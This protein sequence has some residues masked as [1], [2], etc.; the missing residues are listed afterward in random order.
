MNLIQRLMGLML[1]VMFVATLAAC[2]GGGGGGSSGGGGGGAPLTITTGS[3]PNGTVGVAYSVTLQVTGGTSPYTWSV[4]QGSLP[5]WATLNAS[6]G[7]ITG[8]PNAAGTITLTFRATDSNNVTT[9]TNSLTLAIAPAA[10][11]P[12]TITTSSLPSGTVGVAYSASLQASGGTPPYTWSVSQG[13]LPSWATLN[14]NTGAI[15]GTPNAAGTTALTFSVTDSN[16]VI[17]Q[18]SSLNLTIAPAAPPPLAITTPSLPS[19][20]VGATYSTTLQASGGTPPYT[21]SISSGLLPAWASL[22]TSTGAITGTPNVSGTTSF[23][24]QVTDSESPVVSKTQNL[25]ITVNASNTSDGLLSGQYAFMVSGYDSALAGSISVDG[26]G[27]ITGGEED[28]AAPKTS[29]SG[30]NIPIT[31]GTYTVGSDNRGTLSYTDSNGN[32]FTFAFA[33]GGVSNGVAAQGQMIEFDT[34]P[35]EMSGQL[36]LQ[37]AAAFSPSALSGPYVLALPG[38]DATP[39]PDVVIGSF[40]AGPGAISSGLLDQNDMGTVT[41]AQAFTGNLGS[42]DSKGRGTMTLTVGAN[43][44]TATLY[45]VSAGEWFLVGGTSGTPSFVFGGEVVQQSA[46]P[47]SAASLSGPTIFESRSE[48]GVPAPNV[49]FGEITFGSG[50]INAEIDQDDGGTLTLGQSFSGGSW[51]VTSASNGRFLFSPG[52]AHTQ[53]GYW[54]APDLAVMT[55]ESAVT[56]DIGTLEPQSGS[57]FSNSS[58]SGA[59]FLGTLPSLSPGAP[60]QNGGAAPPFNIYSGIFSASSGACSMTLDINSSGATSSGVTGS[61][62]CSVATNGRVTTASG[63]F[64]GWMVSPT[65]FY[66]LN[67][68]QSQPSTPNPVLWIL[69]Q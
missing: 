35:L 6:T 27:N 68:K 7:A 41:S 19:G 69:Q 2:G 42:I 52:G 33:L 26:K 58:L 21:W 31:S 49:T 34:N 18:T 25:S 20:T 16:N 57:G 29:M 60:G 15:T 50:T 64:V 14:A 55:E 53:V 39:S 28:I 47:F 46:G 8:T 66:L 45:I 9:Q 54:I 23:T 63:D 37:S 3:L 32:K 17:T 36:A 22:N 13:S 12:L 51:S 10:P 5:S 24:A 48:D 38:W 67:V 44:V 59:Y 40:T 4:S 61:D 11:P 56:P 62:T 65:K 30:S 1:G 43:N